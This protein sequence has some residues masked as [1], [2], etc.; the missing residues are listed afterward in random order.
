MR[1]LLLYFGIALTLACSA[2]TEPSAEQWKQ[3]A[4]EWR[5]ALLRLHQTLHTSAGFSFWDC[6]YPHPVSFIRAEFI[7]STWVIRHEQRH[8]Q[9]MNTVSSCEVWQA[10]SQ[11]SAFRAAME[12]DAARYER[13]VR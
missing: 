3:A 9:Q 10:L 7:D 5:N 4:I 2:H 12:R 11:D 1:T 8:I 13:G 6:R